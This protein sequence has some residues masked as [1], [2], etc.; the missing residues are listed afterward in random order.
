MQVIEKTSMSLPNSMLLF[1]QKFLTVI[2]PIRSLEFGTGAGVGT[3]LLAKLSK[4]VI[5]LDHDLNWSKYTQQKLSKK[6]IHN[7]AYLVGYNIALPYG[8]FDILLV[9]GPPG[10]LARRD[11]VIRYWKYLKPGATIILDDVF[12]K[13]EQ[14]ALA[15]WKK[16]YGAKTE[17]IKTDRDIGICV[18]PK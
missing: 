5:T 10:G 11:A 3:E 17:I 16:L 9:D 15:T 7:V 8:D 1:L 14:N 6:G 12:R 18:K 2:K 13:D 4:Q